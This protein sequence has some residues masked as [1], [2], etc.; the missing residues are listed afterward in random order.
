M[1]GSASLKVKELLL[2]RSLLFYAI[3][4]ISNTLL[5]LLL[6]FVLNNLF[7]LPYWWSTAIPFAIT[8]V[9]S[10]VFNR[11]FSFKGNGNLWLDMLKFY[12]LFAACYVVAF[13]LAKPASIALMQSANA[14]EKAINNVSYVIGQCVFTPLNYFGQ[15]FLV[16]RKKEAPSRPED[17]TA[18]DK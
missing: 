16:Y 6:E 18:A 8:S 17:E 15:R 4:G 3:I 1:K 13:L 14:S 11:K 9:T 7:G 12:I 10:F 2:D 5:T